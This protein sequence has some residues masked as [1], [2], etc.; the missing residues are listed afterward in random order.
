IPGLIVLLIA[1][2]LFHRFTN[3][4]AW[5]LISILVI[6]IAK[7]IALFPKVWKAYDSDNPSPMEQFIGM[8]G[9]AIDDLDPA[10]YVKVRGELWKAE[11]RD[12]RFPVKEGDKIEVSDVE[13]MTLIVKRINIVSSQ[14]I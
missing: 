14:D 11:I 5:L 6:W 3:I 7:D 2:V 8:N 9:V 1:L 13:G 4:P 10:G 12:S